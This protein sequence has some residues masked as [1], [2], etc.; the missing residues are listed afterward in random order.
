MPDLAHW[1]GGDLAVSP[2]GDLATVDGIELGNQ[3]IVRRLLTILGEYIWHPE[4]GA[5]VPIRVGDVF[6]R[7]E[8]EAVILAQMFEEAAVSRSPE[9]TISVSP[10]QDGVFVSIFY[11]DALT[12][13]QA[14]LQFEATA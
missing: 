1:I 12:G 13:R 11:I 6:D 3:R 10:I 4:Y 2:S 8:I 14:T 7:E 9:P 5:S